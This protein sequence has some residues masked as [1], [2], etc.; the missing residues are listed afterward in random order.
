MYHEA[1]AGRAVTHGT[2]AGE[3]TATQ[4]DM[5]LPWGRS[6]VASD[7]EELHLVIAWSLEEPDRI[8]EAA[9]LPGPRVLGRGG[10][11]AS[12]GAPR[13]A[14]H[15]MRPSS[16]VATPPLDAPRVSRLQLELVPVPA[17]K[18][19]VTSVGKCPML[20]NGE[21]VEQATLEPGDTL[22]LRNALVLLLVRRPRTLPALRAYPESSFP[23]G[24][25]DPHGIVGESPAAWE[26]RDELAL[27]ARSGLHVL[28][29][30]ESGVGKEL[31]ARAVHGLS[32]RADRPFVS[33]N[34]ATFPEG[35][36]DAELFGTVKNY[37]N[38]GSPERP[39]LIGEADGATLF[40]DEIGELP[41]HLQAHLLRV[42]DQGGEY[43]RLGE[44]RV[45]RSD[46]RFIAATN[47]PLDQLKHDFAARFTGRITI[48]GLGDRR[49]DLPLLIRHVLL[50][51]ARSTDYVRS[52]FFERR[53][54]DL[55]EP[56]VAP[57]LVEAL[58]RHAYTHHLRELERLVWTAITTSRDDYVGFTPE[59]R[60]EL[61]TDGPE[62]PG[63]A[64]ASDAPAPDAAAV[65]AA[66]EAS[67][68][69]VTRAAARLGLK[70]RFALYRLLKKLGI[71]A[72]AEPEE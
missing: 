42:L 14:F 71:E 38:A 44:A 46:L 7:G 16:S 9:A 65:T 52:R 40:L 6:D 19:H 36:V 20:V 53:G 24:G 49:D 35:L 62:A 56:R 12:D 50:K 43:Q 10:A 8:G 3:M 22:T 27:A 11:Q 63:D 18:L 45:R 59:V 58:L 33:R 5:G 69:N 29:R 60:A 2:L 47:R 1:C 30:G 68:G 41:A 48:P 64:G 23:F 66:L 31:A 51:A 72:P 61:R 34:A 21:E 39:G 70:N 57:D 32:S 17:Q 37:P 4:P 54:G 13:V 28:L 55:A 26:L 15:R 67:R 25:P